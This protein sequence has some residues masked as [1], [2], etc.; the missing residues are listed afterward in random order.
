MGCEGDIG[1]VCATS[2]CGDVTQ[3]TT[4]YIPRPATSKTAAPC[5]SVKRAGIAC[6]Q[7]HYQM[8]NL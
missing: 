8:S 3:M 4:T 2:E 5:T 1:S 6:S 7:A